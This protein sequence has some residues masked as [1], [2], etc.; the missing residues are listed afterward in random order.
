MKQFLALLL[1]LILLV[2]CGNDRTLPSSQYDPSAPTALKLCAGIRG[3]GQ[4]M[5]THFASLARIVEH[6]GVV[7]G[8]AGSSSTSITMFLYTNMH[9]NS[10]VWS[11]GERPCSYRESTARLA[12]LLKSLQG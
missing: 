2:S 3:N 5:L 4:A 9:R 1:T 12:L 6:Y 7:D 10:E 8:L 11:C